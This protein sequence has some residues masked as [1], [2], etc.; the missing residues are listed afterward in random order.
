V[1]PLFVTVTAPVVC[2]REKGIRDRRRQKRFSRAGISRPRNRGHGA[3][4]IAHGPC[5]LTH[6]AAAGE[7][8]GRRANVQGVGWSRPEERL[9]E[10]WNAVD[11][12]PLSPCSSLDRRTES[13]LRNREGV[14]SRATRDGRVASSRRGR[15]PA[16]LLEAA[17]DHLC[18][19]QLDHVLDLT[20]EFRDALLRTTDACN[21]LQIRGLL[22]DNL[23]SVRR[24]KEAAEVLAP[25]LKEERGKF[26]PS[27]QGFL[28][29]R[30][31]E[32]SAVALGLCRMQVGR[33]LKHLGDR[34]VALA[35]TVKAY[36]ALSRPAH[37]E[38]YAFLLLASSNILRARLMWQGGQ[39]DDAEA[40]LEATMQG[41]TSP[42]EPIAASLRDHTLPL[43]GLDA[44]FARACSWAAYFDWMRGRRVGRG[45]IYFSLFLN[46]K[47]SDSLG[48]ASA[49]LTASRLETSTSASRPEWQARLLRESHEIFVRYDHDFQ[50]RTS[51][52]LAQCLV[53]AGRFDEAEQLIH[54]L[55]Q[56][57]P[58]RA[59]DGN[60]SAAVLDA[61]ADGELARLWM[62][63]HRVA[64]GALPL[65]LCLERAARF[66]TTCEEHKRWLSSRLRIEAILHHGMALVR[67]A[68]AEQV[69]NGRRKLEDAL[70]L[71][72]DEK[73]LR[74]QA[75][76]H[77][78]L[79]DSHADPELIQ[80]HYEQG[81][82][83]LATQADG[84][85][86]SVARR[87]QRRLRERG[88]ESLVLV[89]PAT[90]TQQ[91]VVEQWMDQKLDGATTAQEIAKRLDC[92]LSHA[93]RILAERKKRGLSR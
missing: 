86:A 11:G 44:Q 39:H 65:T 1:H 18:A 68:D 49:L 84:Y 13:T 62:L 28:A 16:Q 56:A 58:T 32:C 59:R 88:G 51:A 29:A 12:V 70:K 34:R 73:R 38:P 8:P 48:R 69:A 91:A 9:A 55:E 72:Q 15:T 75:M 40:L 3:R 35:Q 78:A 37:T 81:A 82:K 22:A 27:E 76:A 24:P 26:S 92:A 74:I 64:S 50:W 53:K 4:V 46:G 77:F 2:P 66:E 17:R 52:Q 25:L 90:A 60:H 87:L 93:Y 54:Q 45:R 71:A 83:L 67:S 36:D 61:L 21:A 31:Q 19:G 10:R 47:T 57:H 23:L 20:P 85:L 42:P 89:V 6:R 33:I 5:I 30:T 14:L 80:K 63:E 43:G 79:A 41:L 7:T